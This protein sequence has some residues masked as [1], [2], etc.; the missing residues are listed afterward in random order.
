M[1]LIFNAT[2]K[3]Q[4]SVVLTSSSHSGK[5]PQNSRDAIQIAKAHKSGIFQIEQTGARKLYDRCYAFTDINYINQDRDDKIKILEKLMDFF[6]SMQLSF[7]ITIVNEYQD[8]NQFIDDIFVNKNDDEYPV[9]ASG[10][11]E[12]IDE[13][14]EEAR[15]YDV[16]RILL[17]TL[18]VKSST[19]DEA[20]SYFLGMDIEIERAF[21]AFKS[22][23]VPLNGEQRLEIIDRFFYKEEAG[24]PYSFE[25]DALYDVIPVSIDNYTDFMLP[26]KVT[27]A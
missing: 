6:K 9:I 22:K 14:K 10:I 3:F 21:A 15:I 7:K 19:Y 24:A 12:W 17:L 4:D 5:Y 20:R 2:K 13:K 25:G 23:I 11:R 26:L 8:M 1:A 27:V 18:T 16:K